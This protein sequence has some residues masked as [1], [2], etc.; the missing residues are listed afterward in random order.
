MAIASKLSVLCGFPFP[1][2]IYTNIFVFFF[3][4][5]Q[6]YTFYTR[7]SKPNRV[8]YECDQISKYNL[9]SSLGTS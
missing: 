5:I 2:V 9:K 6:G 8:I 4:I 3:A 7:N 1:E